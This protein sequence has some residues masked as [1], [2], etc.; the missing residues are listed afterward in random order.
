MWYTTRDHPINQQSLV[1]R[2]PFQ[3]FKSAEAAGT[4]IHYSETLKFFF[5][6]PLGHVVAHYV[7]IAYHHAT[8]N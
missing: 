4:T 7:V 3:D 2:K 1:G 6:V 8:I 5:L